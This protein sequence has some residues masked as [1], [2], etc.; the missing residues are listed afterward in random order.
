MET[1][2]IKDPPAS[3]TYHLELTGEERA[4]LL[5]ALQLL[6]SMLGREEADELRETQALIERLRAMAG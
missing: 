2:Q 3:S 1:A 5:T 4:L 6:E